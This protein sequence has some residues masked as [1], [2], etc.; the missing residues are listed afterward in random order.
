MQVFCTL[1]DVGLR[2]QYDTTI[3]RAALLQKVAANTYYNYQKTN[4]ILI[5]SSR[6]LVLAHHVAKVTHPTLCPNGGFLI[7]SFTPS[8]TIDHL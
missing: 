2:P 7:V 4:A 1:H 5:I 3:E 8:P 6:D